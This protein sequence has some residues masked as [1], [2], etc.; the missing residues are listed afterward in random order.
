MHVLLRIPAGL[1]TDCLSNNVRMA[2]WEVLGKRGKR[3][4]QI[5]FSGMKKVTL[6]ES[7]HLAEVIY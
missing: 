7:K 1:H 6:K 2:F 4:C 3:G 5:L